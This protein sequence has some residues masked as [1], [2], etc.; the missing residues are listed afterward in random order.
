M[1][2]AF[3]H[4]PAERQIRKLDKQF[5]KE[6]D[7]IILQ[8]CE[9]PSCGEPL[10]HGILNG[11]RSF[12]NPPHRVIYKVIEDSIIIYAVGH[13]SSGGDIYEELSRYFELTKT[14]P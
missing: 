6:L 14:K 9:D 1:H 7:R 10:K 13:R 12:H 3:I 4:Q 11:L 5:R 2:K 8:I